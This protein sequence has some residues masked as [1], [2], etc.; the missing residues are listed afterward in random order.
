MRYPVT[1]P[2][3]KKTHP[4]LV[5]SASV[6]QQQHI[7]P[8]K[9]STCQPVCSAAHTQL[10]LTWLQIWDFCRDEF[11][12]CMQL[13]NR[14]LTH[15]LPVSRSLTQ[16]HFS[17]VA[18]LK[19]TKPTLWDLL[20]RQLAT[21]LSFCGLWPSPRRSIRWQRAMWVHSHHKIGCIPLH[22]GWRELTLNLET[23]HSEKSANTPPIFLEISELWRS[24]DIWKR[25]TWFHNLTSIP[26]S[27]MS[28]DRPIK[29][30]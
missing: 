22:L 26:T 6:V 15:F 12:R 27:T 24:V 23:R 28:K 5:H 2:K 13:L 9:P 19:K 8:S 14:C 3:K 16:F 11:R 7:D 20:P 21:P 29:A 4:C 25:K 30:A 17:W 1:P 10:H 18:C